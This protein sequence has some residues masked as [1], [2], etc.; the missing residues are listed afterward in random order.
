MQDDE[1]IKAAALVRQAEVKL[2]QAAER[3]GESLANKGLS[4]SCTI[5]ANQM[6]MLARQISPELDRAALPPVGAIVFDANCPDR[7][8]EVVDVHDSLPGIY[9]RPEG[10]ERQPYFQPWG[11]SWRVAE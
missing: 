6:R 7:R 5:F 4:E 2:R 1:L 9:V 3:L 11:A 8:Y 10:T